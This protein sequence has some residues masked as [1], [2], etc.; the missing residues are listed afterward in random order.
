MIILLFIII[1]NN[2]VVINHIINHTI[3]IINNHILTII[4]SSRLTT[5]FSRFKDL[6]LR[7][8]PQ[9]SRKAEFRANRRCSENSL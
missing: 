2:I 9:Q 6:L 3:T 1:N 7:L 8:L 5:D 4:N